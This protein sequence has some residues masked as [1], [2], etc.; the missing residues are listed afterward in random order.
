[1]SEGSVDSGTADFHGGHWVQDPDST[2][3]R[4][5]IWVFVREHAES[6]LVD[7]KTNT[8]MNILFCRLEPSITGGLR[9]IQ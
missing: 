6:A 2:L 8:R 5:E 4:L 3:K 1:M 7:A 9:S